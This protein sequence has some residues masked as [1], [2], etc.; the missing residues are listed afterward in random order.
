VR[1]PHLS[2]PTFLETSSKKCE[3]D[4]HQR[5]ETV[6]HGD[7]R[8]MRVRHEPGVDVK[9]ARIELDGLRGRIVVF[10]QMTA[11]A[12]FAHLI[13]KTN[14]NAADQLAA[15]DAETR[16]RQWHCR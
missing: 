2:K 9:F 11:F 1:D 7:N 16:Q 12:E 10:G 14:A 6:N 4:H 3:S 5:A 15:G 8:P 13:E